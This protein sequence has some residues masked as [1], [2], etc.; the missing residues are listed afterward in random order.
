M[1]KI[2]TFHIARVGLLSALAVVAICIFRIPGPD[3]RLY[4]HLGETVILASAVLLG[5]LG[6]AFVG[7]I[8]SALADLL[9]GATLWAPFSFLIHGAEAWLVGTLS[10]ARGG[11]R[12]FLAMT[13]GVCLMIVGYTFM[14]GFLYGIAV[15]WVEFFGD[16]M[17][18]LL[19][20]ATAFPFVRLAVH[21]FPWLMSD[22]EGR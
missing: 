14:A 22:R 7:A 10:D 17:Q 18:G 5:R 11:R 15:V 12:D 8:S 2:G 4:F 1:S 3:G 16:T 21:R 19:G 6:G 9:L 20:L 13:T